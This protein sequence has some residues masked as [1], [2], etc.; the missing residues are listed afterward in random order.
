MTRQSWYQLL[1]VVSG[2]GIWYVSVVFAAMWSNYM[3]AVAGLTCC[4]ALIGAAYLHHRRSIKRPENN[5]P[6]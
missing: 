5:P 4:L 6:I 3:W 2:T 1:M